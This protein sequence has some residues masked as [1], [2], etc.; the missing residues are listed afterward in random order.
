MKINFDNLAKHI[1]QASEDVEAVHA[2]SKKISSR[3]NS[4][5]QVDLIKISE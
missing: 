2:S 1:N 5:E 4:I 3:F